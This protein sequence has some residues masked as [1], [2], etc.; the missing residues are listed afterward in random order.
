MFEVD[1]CKPIPIRM[2]DGK[3]LQPIPYGSETPNYYDGTNPEHCH[4]CNAKIGG[5]HH[6]GCDWEECPNCESQLLSCGCI[7][8]E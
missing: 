6:I 7:E 4:D 3:E 2:K 5:Y 8:D 1:G